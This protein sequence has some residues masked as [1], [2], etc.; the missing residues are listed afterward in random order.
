MMSN[1][2]RH[3]NSTHSRKGW[4]TTAEVRSHCFCVCVC[5]CVCL[6]GGESLHNE[7]WMN[8]VKSLPEASKILGTT[9]DHSATSKINMRVRRGLERTFN[10]FVLITR[11]LSQVAAFRKEFNESP[12]TKPVFTPDILWTRASYTCCQILH[13]DVLGVFFQFLTA[14]LRKTFVNFGKSFSLSERLSEALFNAKIF[15]CFV[16]RAHFTKWK[17]KCERDFR[18]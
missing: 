1:E 7:T 4:E 14:G 15:I 17:T 18:S 11:S 3:E 13:C 9:S 2:Q 12:K 5:V 10:Q 6:C 16:V 8:W